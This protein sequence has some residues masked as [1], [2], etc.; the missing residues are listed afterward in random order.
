M[1]VRLPPGPRRIAS[2][3]VAEYPHL[4]L[5]EHEVSYGGASSFSVQTLSLSDWCVAVAVTELGQ[6]V[7]VEQHRHGVDALTWEPAGGIVDQGESPAVAA[8]RELLEETGFTGDDVEP[9]GWVHP[10]PAMSSN[11]VHFFLLPRVRQV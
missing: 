2:R 11:K 8:R 5:H 4:T 1:P 7:L 10:N 6:W 9:L 3:I